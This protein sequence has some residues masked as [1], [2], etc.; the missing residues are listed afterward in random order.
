M[1]LK[2]TTYSSINL[3]Q[4]IIFF[5]DFNYNGIFNTVQKCKSQQNVLQG[6]KKNTN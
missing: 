1:L 2:Y 3:I 5:F 4:C 6:K